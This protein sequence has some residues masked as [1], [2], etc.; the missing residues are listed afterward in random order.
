[1]KPPGSLPIAI[2]AA[3]V[4]FGCAGRPTVAAM[5]HAEW[6]AIS[7]ESTSPDRLYVSD[8]NTSPGT[9]YIFT[10]PIS[11][12]SAPTAMIETPNQA[13]G[14]AFDTKHRLIVAN[15]TTGYTSFSSVYAFRQPILDGATPAFGLSTGRWCGGNPRTC[16]ASTAQNVAIGDGSLVLAAVQPYAKTCDSRGCR[17]LYYTKL[18]FFLD[19]VSRTSTQ[20]FEIKTFTPPT[21]TFV[22]FDRHGSLWLASPSTLQQYKPPFSS[23]RAPTLVISASLVGG[24]AFDAAG[25]MYVGAADGVD[26]YYPPFSVSMKKAF[27]IGVT[28][29][30]EL[31]FDAPG[32]LYVATGT[33]LVAFSP[34]FGAGSV[35]FATL[36]PLGASGIAIGP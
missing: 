17:G 19:P 25:N 33:S 6:A 16:Y 24:L 11:N 13:L 35:P 30:F 15:W 9:V 32:N 4:A 23:G 29:P 7:A 5:P 31:A 10:L 3:I 18:S 8:A 14:I 20:A 36:T 27:T 22:A 2:L 28:Q 1:M 26:V 34:P 12:A 21:L